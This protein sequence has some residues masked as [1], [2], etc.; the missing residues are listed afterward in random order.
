MQIETMIYSIRN[1]RVMIDSELA[2]L[3]RV[4]TK[5]L[6]QAVKRNPKRFPEDFMFECDSSEL[7]DLRSQFVTANRVN[8]WNFKRRT[9]PMLFTENG[10]AMLSTVLNSDRAIHVNMMLT[11]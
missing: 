5:I 10:V 11:G 6:N 9:M 2:E 4:E 1:Q 8:T 7:E 3:Y